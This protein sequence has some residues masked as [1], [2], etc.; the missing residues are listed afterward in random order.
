MN[1]SRRL[2]L[3]LLTSGAAGRFAS[4]FYVKGKRL[5]R[6]SVDLV[7]PPHCACCAGALEAAATIPFCSACRERIVPAAL[8]HCRRCAAV[9]NPI[10]QQAPDCSRCRTERFRFDRAFA[11]ARYQ[12]V[13]REI[14]LRMKRS[15]EEPLMMAM[16]RLLAQRFADDLQS[17]KPDVVVPIPMHWTRRLMRGTN[18]PEMIGAV[19]ARHLGAIFGPRSLRRKRRTRKLAE[20]TRQERKRTLRDAFRVGRGCDFTGAHVVLVDDVLTTGTTCD[21]AARA[22]KKAGAAEVTVL[23]AARAYPGD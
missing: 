13:L 1:S 14:V 16:G 6:A 4:S 17:L 8:A 22:L 5:A 7:Y 20:L 3:S 2:R 11:L 12:G 19:L 9:T 18:S 21:I 15:S 23:V 10:E